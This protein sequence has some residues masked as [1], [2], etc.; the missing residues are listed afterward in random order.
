MP[1]FDYFGF[2]RKKQFSV[3]CSDRIAKKRKAQL[4]GF[5]QRNLLSPEHYSA[6]PIQNHCSGMESSS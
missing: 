6:F 1:F 5:R 3:A 2:L 4:P